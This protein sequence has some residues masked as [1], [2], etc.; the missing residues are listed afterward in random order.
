MLSFSEVLAEELSGTGVTVT[1]LCPGPTASGFQ[2]RAD[3]HASAL[4][5]GKRLPT[6]EAV[7]AAGYRAMQTG[8]RVVIPG[9]L[10]WMMAQSVRFT[11]RRLVTAL[12]R[13]LSR[14]VTV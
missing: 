9:C 3:M 12:V 11:P 10:N 5:R 4:V 1:T 14:P 13:L 2:D 6:A 8:R 7:A